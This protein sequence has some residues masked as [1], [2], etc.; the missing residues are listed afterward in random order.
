MKTEAGKQDAKITMVVTF[1]TLISTGNR[2][3]F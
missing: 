3:E 1:L 2:E